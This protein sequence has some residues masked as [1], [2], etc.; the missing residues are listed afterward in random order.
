MVSITWSTRNGFLLRWSSCPLYGKG[1]QS[2]LWPL[3]SSIVPPPW[4]FLKIIGI[5]LFL[6]SISSILSRKNSFFVNLKEWRCFPLAFSSSLGHR[7]TI[8]I[9]WKHLPY[10]LEAGSSSPLSL[11]LAVFKVLM[12]NIH[13]T[14]FLYNGAE[15]RLN[16]G[17]LIIWFSRWESQRP[18]TVK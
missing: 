15:V 6:G 9:L 11:L 2:A 7:R 5:P 3:F 14:C 10:W 17:R 13:H 18:F 4:N 1:Y 8:H 12:A 16:C